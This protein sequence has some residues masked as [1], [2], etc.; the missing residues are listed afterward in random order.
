[1]LFCGKQGLALRGHWDDKC[2]SDDYNYCHNPGNF[3]ELVNFRP[4]TDDVLRA[5]LESSSKNARYTSKTIQNELIN[6]IAS[7]IRQNIVDEVRRAKYYSIIA[8]ETTDV[9]NKEKLSIS[10]SYVLDNQIYEVF[11]N[12]KSSELLGR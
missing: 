5:H 7:N 8:D 3:I 4:Q 12:L 6:V 11:L 10:L 9:S 2:F 1:M